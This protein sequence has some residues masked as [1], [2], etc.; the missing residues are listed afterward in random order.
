M[1]EAYLYWESEIKLF[2]I[3]E[4]LFYGLVCFHFGLSCQWLYE[5]LT[6]V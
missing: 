1:L 5:R 6:D 3:Q 2:M 4:P